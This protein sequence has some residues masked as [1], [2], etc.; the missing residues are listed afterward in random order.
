MLVAASASGFMGGDVGGAGH[1]T[2]G[3]RKSSLKLPSSSEEGLGV[4][5][6]WSF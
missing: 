1:L 6:A 4:E 5:D 2:I 3:V